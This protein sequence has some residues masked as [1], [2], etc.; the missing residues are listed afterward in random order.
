[1]FIDEWK[2]LAYYRNHVINK[3]GVELKYGG[4]LDSVLHEYRRITEE[5]L[6]EHD[7]FIERISKICDKRWRAIKSKKYYLKRSHSG[8]YQWITNPMWRTLF[9]TKD[10]ALIGT[11]LNLQRSKVDE[12]KKKKEK[13]KQKGPSN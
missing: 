5:Y 2:I 7:I 9:E 1:M 13:K 12:T 11:F 10:E 6:W 4:C 3:I 8:K